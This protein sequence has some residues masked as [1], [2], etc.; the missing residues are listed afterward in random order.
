MAT[1]AETNAELDPAG[2]G[3]RAKAIIEENRTSSG[4]SPLT[5]NYYCLGGTDRPGKAGWVTVTVA[6]NAATQAAAV[7]AG[8]A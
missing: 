3:M 4:G 8:L 2:T 5:K 7:L 6:D 1:L